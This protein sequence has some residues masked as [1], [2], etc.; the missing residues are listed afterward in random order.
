MSRLAVFSL[1]MV[2]NNLVKS[3]DLRIRQMSA[4][5]CVHENMCILNYTYKFT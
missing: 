2:D 3:N 5:V 1:L 4:Q